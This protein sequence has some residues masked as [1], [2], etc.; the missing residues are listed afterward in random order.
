MLLDSVDGETIRM[1]HVPPHPQVYDRP[2][3]IRWAV[4]SPVGPRS[5]TW[6]VVGN[7][8]TDDVYL[9][10]RDRIGE[11]KVSLHPVKWRL[12]YT[13]L[14]QT[15][16]GTDGIDRVLFRWE[17][18]P[19]FHPGWRRGATVVFAHSNL[20]AGYPEKPVKQGVVAFYPV[21]Q[22]GWGLRFD[23]MLGAPSRDDNVVVEGAAAEV[24][25]M[26][27]SSGVMVWIVVT[28]VKTDDDFEANMAQLRRDSIRRS[29]GGSPTLR[30][31]GWGADGADGVP[32]LYDLSNLAGAPEPSEMA[33]D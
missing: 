28:E 16:Y 7:A 15:R 32:V 29:G 13:E 6:N 23:L 26:T 8:K 25:R 24:G 31:W 9:G 20:G 4:G 1:V 22:A 30:G 33:G 27:L 10:V 3:T 5:S 17:K 19:E 12:A 2:D 18:P 21:R 11:I 14:G